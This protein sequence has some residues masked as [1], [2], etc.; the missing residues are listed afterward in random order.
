MT[1]ALLLAE[2][3]TVTGGQLVGAIA[4]VGAILGGMQ[5]WLLK[6]LKATASSAPSRDEVASMIQRTAP[7]VEDRKLILET[8]RKNQEQ[9]TK[10]T[11]AVVSLEKTVERLRGAK[12]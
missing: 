6:V 12:Q 11:D 7:Y 10:L 8:L 4:A 5:A 1:T 9:I 2:A 3:A